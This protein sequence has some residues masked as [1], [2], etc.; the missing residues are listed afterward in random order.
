MYFVYLLNDFILFKIN[1]RTNL[2]FPTLTY[3]RSKIKKKNKV[4]GYP[5]LL[6]YGASQTK[7]DL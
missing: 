4:G 7:A 2:N 3:R 6:F 1:N 5:D